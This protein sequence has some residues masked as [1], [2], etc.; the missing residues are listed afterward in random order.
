MQQNNAKQSVIFTIF[1]SFLRLYFSEQC[2]QVIIYSLSTYCVSNLF[3]DT[4]NKLF[5]SSELYTDIALEY[6]YTDKNP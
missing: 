5:A 3:I 4:L 2:N 1:T 6:S